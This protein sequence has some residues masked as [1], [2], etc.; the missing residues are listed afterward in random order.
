LLISGAQPLLDTVAF[1][2]KDDYK[3]IIATDFERERQLRDITKV[4]TDSGT[5][6]VIG[7]RNYL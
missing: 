3:R 1:T 4:S 5:N 7:N 2:D 6:T